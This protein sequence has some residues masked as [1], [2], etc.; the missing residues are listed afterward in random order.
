MPIVQEVD[1]NRNWAKN[2]LY[3]G[4]ALPTKTPKSFNGGFIDLSTLVN[5]GKSAIDFVSNNKDLIQSGVS[6]V[7]KFVDLGKSISDTVKTS[8]EL[9]KIRDIRQDRKKKEYTITP[10]MEEKLKRLGSGFATFS[11]SN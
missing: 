9:D 6:T 7:G 2:T 11:K 8:K 4:G 1:K 5:V 3:S 10:E